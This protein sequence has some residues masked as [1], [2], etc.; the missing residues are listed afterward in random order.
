[1]YAGAYSRGSPALAVSRSKSLGTPKGAVE[2]VELGLL[3]EGVA[4]DV[5]VLAPLG[6]RARGARGDAPHRGGLLTDRRVEDARL[7]ARGAKASLHEAYPP[8]VLRVRR[9]HPP[10]GPT[11]GAEERGN[12]C[13]KSR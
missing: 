10:D 3:H 11:F 2:P 13:D 7:G 6:D 8:L 4:H 9:I 1:M 5:A 12:P